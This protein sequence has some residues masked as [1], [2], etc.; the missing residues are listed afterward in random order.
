MICEIPENDEVWN[1]SLLKYDYILGYK[2]DN[3]KTVG[4]IGLTRVF[5]NLVASRFFVLPQ[6]RNKGIG[7][8]IIEYCKELSASKQCRL[9]LYVDKHEPETERLCAFYEKRGFREAGLERAQE[10]RVTFDDE[11]DHLYSYSG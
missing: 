9:L 5:D 8:Q 4:V 2:V 7:S 3:Y 10:W 11:F 1:E 6:H